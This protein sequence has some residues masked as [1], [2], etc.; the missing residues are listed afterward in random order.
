MNNNSLLELEDVEVSIN[1]EKIIHNLNFILNKGEICALVGHNGAGKTVTMKTIMGIQEKDK[2]NIYLNN[3]NIDLDYLKYK[4]QYSY[5]PEEPMLFTEL[6]VF[7]HFQLYG[8]SYGVPEKLFNERVNYYVNEFELNGKLDEFPDNLSKGM[9]QKVNIISNLITDT[10][11]LIIDEPFIGLDENSANFLEN[12]IKKKSKQGTTILL[13]S[14][15]I[16]RV[17][18]FCHSFIMLRNGEIARR[19]KIDHLFQIERRIST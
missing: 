17:K 13:T 9:R 4:S 10:P 8:T 16:E 7:Q 18:K 14:H 3:I 11:L 12:E 5:I 1:D 6:T 15:V 2:G 19:G